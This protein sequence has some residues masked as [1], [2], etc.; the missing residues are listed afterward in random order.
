MKE[1]IQYN[2]E[3]YKNIILPV[4]QEIWH[5]EDIPYHYDLQNIHYSYYAIKDYWELTLELA[6]ENTDDYIVDILSFQNCRSFRFFDESLR[7]MDLMSQYAKINGRRNPTT[8]VKVENSAY[9]K[10]IA[11]LNITPEATSNM[12]HYLL[13]MND[14]VLDVACTSYYVIYHEEY[15]K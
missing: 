10:L 8:L 14:H 13:L 5:P 6:R 12:S 11:K 4:A 1:T 7:Y 9:L 15:S 3:D 2:E